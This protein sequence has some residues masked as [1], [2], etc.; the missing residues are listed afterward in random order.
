MLPLLQLAWKMLRAGF[1]VTLLPLA[2]FGETPYALQYAPQQ[3]AP[4]AP[5]Q[6]DWSRVAELPPGTPIVVHQ[7]GYQFPIQCRLVWINPKALACDTVATNVPSQRL[8]VQAAS[9]DSVHAL[10]YAPP[11]PPPA[12][13]YVAP[14][15][16]PPVQAYTLAPTPRYV[17]PAQVYR[18]P[19]RH[20][21]PI[22][23][24]GVVA[25]A[26]VGG[27]IG[28]NFST[29]GGFLGAALGGIGGAGISFAAVEAYDRPSYPQG[30]GH[31]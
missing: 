20:A 1:L 30:Y 21:G 31:P 4:V 17:Q 23:A 9:V 28:K 14:Y 2:A 18:Q 26:L 8:V 6:S 10:S 3:Y 12:P 16:Q 22:I 7:R 27:L 15:A 5:P 19:E 25:G 29:T 24:L 11:P 13:T